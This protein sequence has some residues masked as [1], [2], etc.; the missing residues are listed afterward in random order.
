MGSVY[1]FT[2]PAGTLNGD[3][4]TWTFGDGQAAMGMSPIVHTYPSV[5]GS[6]LATL[7]IQRPQANGDTCK[8]KL[9]ALINTNPCPNL[10]RNGDFSLG[11]TGFTSGLLAG[12]TAASNCNTGYY[13]VSNNFT[14]K[15]NSWP[16]VFDHTFGNTTGS[17]MSIDGTTTAAG[18][19][20]VWRNAAIPVSPNTT[21]KF[22]FWLNS[23][24][25]TLPV[26]QSLNLD[27][28]IDGNGSTAN[29]TPII[30]TPVITQ[31][32]LGSN[33]TWKQYSTLWVCPSGVT[34]VDLAIRQAS[35]GA[36]RD[37]GLDDISFTCVS[38]EDFMTDVMNFGI[39]STLV[40]G[41]TYKYCVSPNISSSDIVQWDLDC[42]GSVDATTNSTCQN[43]TLS[44]ANNQ[45]CA[46]VL[47]INKPGD[48]C[49][50]KVN[51]CLPSVSPSPVKEV[52][53][54]I[55]NVKPNPTTQSVL[56]TL[57]EGIQ[58]IVGFLK[59]STIE[60][61]I[62][63]SIPVRSTEIYMELDVLPAGLYFI[64]FYDDK[65]IMLTQPTKLVKQ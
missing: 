36:F 7:Y 24:Y 63:K 58:N 43:F 65:G 51:T 1:T 49:R 28:F 59:L 48:T 35:S 56:V 11:D 9:S 25:S 57:P 10:I 5:S 61:R 16:S 4:L 46:T 27:M 29:P 13:C 21:Y 40:S 3:I 32:T 60:G 23:V 42:N 15:C 44:G 26:G 38:C 54:P 22:S 53:M 20:E 19:T 12:C 14:N 50:V 2:K 62:L 45:I 18:A 30:I 8:V 33:S 52:T 31:A 17:F 6:Y 41:T 34:T 39:K 47:H 64:T 37:F 55:L